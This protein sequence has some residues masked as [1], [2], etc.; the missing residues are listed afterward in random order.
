M[1]K[2]VACSGISFFFFLMYINLS[3]LCIKNWWQSGEGGGIGLFWRKDHSYITLTCFWFFLPS[4]PPFQANI[5]FLIYLPYQLR[6][7]SWNPPNTSVTCFINVTLFKFLYVL[8]HNCSKGASGATAPSFLTIYLKCWC[9]CADFLYFF[10]TIY[11][12]A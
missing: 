3:R 12:A 10:A 9:F 5:R 7:N 6:K 11:F 1:I 8:L 2:I 4:H